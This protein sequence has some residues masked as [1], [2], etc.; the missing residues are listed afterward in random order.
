[1]SAEPSKIAPPV[2]KTSRCV[3]PDEGWWSEDGDQC[4]LP[5]EY[6]RD[7]TRVKR[8]AFVGHELPVT[9]A[10]EFG[11]MFYDDMTVKLVWI[12][13]GDEEDGPGWAGRYD[14]MCYKADPFDPRS[15]PC[16][17]VTFG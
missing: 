13:L 9:P 7:A 12:R 1:V 17:E 6:G 3:F 2:E 5:L 10:R 16:W 11:G 15:Y 14:E 4:W 8:L